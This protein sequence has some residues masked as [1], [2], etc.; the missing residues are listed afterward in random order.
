MS[1]LRS[2]LDEMLAF[3]DAQLTLEELMT[4][5][6]ELSH[7]EQIAEVLRARKVRSIDARDGSRRLGYSSRSRT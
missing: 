2:I 7:V 6:V 5:V 1:E 4:D 3:D